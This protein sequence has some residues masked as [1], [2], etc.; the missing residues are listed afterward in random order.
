MPLDAMGCARATLRCSTSFKLCLERS[1]NLEHASR[2]GLFIAIIIFSK[3]F[4]VSL[5]HQLVLITPMP[6]VHAARRS[7]RLS[8]PVN[9]LDCRR[10]QSMR[11][12]VDKFMNLVI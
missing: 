11:N 5:S 10:V 8:G 6:F 7:Y 12:A 4:L 1:G 2:W 9:H 3:D